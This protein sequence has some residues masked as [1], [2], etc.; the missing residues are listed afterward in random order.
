MRKLPVTE[1][2]INLIQYFYRQINSLAIYINCGLTANPSVY[3]TLCL[4][5]AVAVRQSKGMIVF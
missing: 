3:G 4:L 1:N 5:V 2:Y